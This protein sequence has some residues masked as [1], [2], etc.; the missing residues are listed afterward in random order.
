[1][2]P[3]TKTDKHVFAGQHTEHHASDSTQVPA[4]D[5]KI[6]ALRAYRRARGLC[7][8]CAEKWSRGHKCAS[9]VPL[10]AMHELWEMLQVDMDSEVGSEE[11]ESDVQFQMLLSQEAVSLG[12]KSTPLKFLGTIQGHEVI[13]LVDSGS[14]NSFLNAG[15]ASALLGISQSPRPVSAVSQ[16]PSVAFSVR[17]ITSAVVYSGCVF[18]I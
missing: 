13:I 3:P 1:L 15:L 5:D 17:I 11:S 16:W 6:A 10:Q 4:P 18:C 2:P 14:S 7:Q 8:F 9:S 12:G